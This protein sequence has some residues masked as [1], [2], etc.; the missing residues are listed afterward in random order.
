MNQQNEKR[1]SSTLQEIGEVLLLSLKY[2]PCPD[3]RLTGALE[4]IDCIVNDPDNLRECEYFFKSS[5]NSYVLFF[6]SN[7]IY[8]LKT[9]NDLYLTADVLK[10]LA[11]VWKNFIKRNRAY[12]NYFKVHDAYIGVFKKYYKEDSSFIAKLSNVNDLR[13]QFLSDDMAADS[14]LAKLEKF[15]QLTEEVVNVMKPTYFF[16][17]DFFREMNISTGNVP[18]DADQ[19]E[20][21]GLA[22]FGH[23]IYTYRKIVESSCKSLGLLEGI[24]LLLRKRKSTRQFRIIDGK[25]KFLTTGEIYEYYSDKFDQMKKE[26]VEIK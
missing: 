10:W 11:S 24:Y 26:L 1:L 23:D 21:A 22:Y 20:K 7:I 13:D 6:F 4:A 16:L 2:Q 8:N 3:D 19:I 5:G 9:K 15:F 25:K 14:E 18:D 17:L 12:Q